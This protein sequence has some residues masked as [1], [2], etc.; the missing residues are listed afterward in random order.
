MDTVLTG[1]CGK[2]ARFRVDRDGQRLVIS[3]T[4]AIDDTYM[5]E[6]ATPWEAYKHTVREVVVHK[7]ISQIGD[8]AFF[9][10]DALERVTIPGSVDTLGS[11]C[12]SRCT[13]LRHVRLPEG[14]RVLCPKVFDGNTSMETVE[15]PKSLEYI[16]FKNF[17]GVPL[18]HVYYSGTE[19]QWKKIRIAV[20]AGGNDNLFAAQI[21]F[22]GE[23]EDLSRRYPDLE[24][25]SLIEASFLAREL[26]YRPMGETYGLEEILDAGF[27]CDLL[28]RR[29]GQP[30]QWSGGLGWAKAHGMTQ[31]GQLSLDGLN[32]LLNEAAIYNGHG[33]AQWCAGKELATRREALPVLARFFA[34]KES[35]ADRYRE[36]ADTL[37]S[38][39]EQGGDGKLHIFSPWLFRE[40]IDNKP[41]DCTIVVFPKGKVMVID[42]ALKPF[43]DAIVQTLKDLG[44]GNIDYMVASHPHDD[45]CGGMTNVCDW[46]VEN[47]GV[48]REFWSS[49]FRGSENSGEPQMQQ[50]AIDHGLVIH[51][52]ITEGDS[53]DID[54]VHIALFNPDKE[55]TQRGQG[56]TEYANN[57]S[58]AMRFGYGSSSYMTSGDLYH[59]QE[60]HVAE[61]YG[62]KL[63][64]DV[65]KAN[66]HGIFTSNTPYWR[67]TVAPKIVLAENDDIGTT[68]Q[69]EWWA[70]NGVAYYAT[71]LD[72][73]V[74]ISMDDRAN[75]RVLHQL[76]SELRCQYSGSIEK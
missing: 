45:H 55:L 39:V 7:G 3:G 6:V 41:G 58:L 30:G 51:N 71:G 32:C 9:E 12:L 75:Y 76:D 67:N 10:M 66:H 2:D 35:R 56:R 13:S 31:E 4:G 69:A 18:K 68:S 59:L 33:P 43:S 29:G 8:N 11:R 38:A 5:G 14:I 22:L 70:R 62:T 25:Q 23:E 46:I 50:W 15:L 53:F 27:V 34:S 40:N 19:S 16:N 47:G 57:M 26:D 20:T 42:A 74:L 64:S 1:T 72:G 52:Q 44:I 60:K 24:G 21:H 36:I 17:L 37:R 54:G 65:M 61:K 49:P 63:Q 48:V 28:Y 73:A